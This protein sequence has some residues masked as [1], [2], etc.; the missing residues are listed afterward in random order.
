MA[1][2]YI[3]RLNELKTHVAVQ[4]VLVHIFGE[5]FV[6][7]RFRVEIKDLV[8]KLVDIV[9]VVD[10]RVLLGLECTFKRQ[11]NTSRSVKAIRQV[12]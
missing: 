11:K 3:V 12:W 8:L 9:S 1:G 5:R 7:L 4:N 6:R 2:K 10:Q